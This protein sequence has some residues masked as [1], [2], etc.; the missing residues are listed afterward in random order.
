MQSL[1]FRKAELKDVEQLLYLINRAYRDD[2]ARSW[3]NEA[4]FVSGARIDEQQLQQ[5]LADQNFHLYVAEI[6]NDLSSLSIV[7]CI[8]LTFNTQEVEI[9]TFCVDPDFQNAGVGKV[10]LSFAEAQALLIQPNLDVYVMF[11]LDIRTE[12]LAYYQRRGYRLTELKISYPLD[13][14]VG[15]PLRHIELQQMLKNIQ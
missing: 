12:L 15:Q 8:G 4:K 6:D 9:G 7:A 1:K 11:V 10:V 3:T 5:A 2:T 14:N 13:A